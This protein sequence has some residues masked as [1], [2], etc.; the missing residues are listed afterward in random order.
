MIKLS[1]GTNGSFDIPFDE[2]VEY[3]FEKKQELMVSIEELH[4]SIKFFN[5]SY[6]VGLT[7][8]HDIPGEE[9]LRVSMTA[10]FDVNDESYLVL[11]VVEGYKTNEGETIEG[12]AFLDIK[13]DKDSVQQAI[14]AM[15]DGTIP[16]YNKGIEITEASCPYALIYDEE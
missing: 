4:K 6:C 1:C 12:D 8:W 9:R 5:G 11:R 3:L 7:K 15:L 13:V 14:T 16:L 10:S 2:V